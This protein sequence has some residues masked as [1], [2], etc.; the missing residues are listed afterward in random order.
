MKQ[1]NEFNYSIE[2]VIGFSCP[3]KKNNFNK[4]TN[5]LFC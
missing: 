4:W 1:I 3:S 2:R 5:S